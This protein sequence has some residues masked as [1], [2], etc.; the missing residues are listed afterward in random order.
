M[1]YLLIDLEGQSLSDEEKEL[2][3]HPMVAGLIFFQRNFSCFNQLSELV[4][5]IRREI[6]KLLCKEDLSAP[7]IFKAL[8]KN[9]PVYRQSI[10][11]ALDVLS[12]SGLI[13]KYYNFKKRGIYYKIKM[14]E[15]KIDLKKMRIQ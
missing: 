5:E 8:G 7:Q 15:I 10:N 1:S 13:I 11:K 6:I 14:K 12:S 3:Q 2:I 9:A 4:T